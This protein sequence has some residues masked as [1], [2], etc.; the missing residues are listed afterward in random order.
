[1]K[2]RFFLLIIFILL[3]SVFFFKKNL[4]A[5][6]CEIGINLSGLSQKEL[7][8]IKSKCE[9]KISQLAKKRNTLASEINYIDTQI[10]LT[11]LKVTE[12]EKKIEQTEKEIGVLNEKIEGLDESLDRLSNLL[13]KKIIVDYKNKRISLLSIFL[14]SDQ[15]DDLVNRIKYI[16]TTRENNQKLII[17]VQNAK[18][19]FEEQKKLREE[20]KVELDSLKVILAKQKNDLLNQQNAKRK[21]LADTQ[22]SEVIY[23]RIVAQ[24]KAQLASFINYVRSF[25]GASILSN[26]TS[27]DGWGCYYN[28][29]DNQ[30]GNFVINNSYDCNDGTSTECS[31]AKVGCLVTSVAMYASHLGYKI[32]PLDIATNSDNFAA[33]TALLKKGILYAKGIK[34]ERIPIGSAL[35]PEILSNKPVIVGI[36]YGPY[37]THF[38][39]IKKYENGNYIMNDPF[40]ENGK[41]KN[42]TDY[43]SLNSVFSVEIINI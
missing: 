12:T 30:W 29:R 37:G 35:S 32:N 20:K 14:E 34:I 36:K 3:L 4:S 31:I 40:I 15:I 39:L 42:F 33:N 16:K 11:N 5:I 9:E 28:Q 13:L 10:Y 38:L 27:C 43:Y 7:Q 41:D 6:E 23:Q 8:E 1:M 25:G 17:Q 2:R 24:A 26:Q 21:L 22:N 18:I 19:N